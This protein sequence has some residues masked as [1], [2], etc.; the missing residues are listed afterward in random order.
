MV[1]SIDHPHGDQVERT[2]AATAR[3]S[4]A[5]ARKVV[6]DIDT[7]RGNGCAKR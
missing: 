6:A 1:D 5:E 3:R 2:A 4:A 7:S